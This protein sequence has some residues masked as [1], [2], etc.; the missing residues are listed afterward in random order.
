MKRAC[1]CQYFD[2]FNCKSAIQQIK[3]D[4]EWI[5]FMLTLVL[6]LIIPQYSQAINL[7][8][9]LKANN[10]KS[11]PDSLI[12]YIYSENSQID[13]LPS[14]KYIYQYNTVGELIIETISNY[15]KSNRKWIPK[16]KL[17]YENNNLIANYDWYESRMKWCAYREEFARYDSQKKAQIFETYEDIL[18][19]CSPVC[20]YRAEVSYDSIQKTRTY[21]ISYFDQK[22]QELQL[23][24]KLEYVFKDDTL[25]YRTRYEYMWNN[26]LKI[27]QKNSKNDYEY[28]TNNTSYVTYYWD[29]LMNNWIMKNKNELNFDAKKR[30]ISKQTLNMDS[31]GNWILETKQEI[32]YDRFGKDSLT[33]YSV[34]KSGKLDFIGKAL[35]INNKFGC[36]YYE[37]IYSYIS[38][39]IWQ[40]FRKVDSVF[41]EKGKNTSWIKYSWN[42]TDSSWNN[43]LKFEYKYNNQGILLLSYYSF[44]WNQIYNVWDSTEYKTYTYDKDTNKLC[45]TNYMWNYDLNKLELSDKIYYY[46]FNSTKVNNAIK[47]VDLKLYPNPSYGM[48]NIY[49]E[50][51]EEKE[52]K[53]YNSEG[54]LV[55]TLHLSRG[56]NSIDL[57]LP[58]GFYI[59]NTNSKNLTNSHKLII[60]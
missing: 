17:V 26:E 13:S 34:F 45:E 39:G 24:S 25:N 20:T 55:E 11:Q 3:N 43:D 27:W 59:I 47:N 29:T 19:T 53:V 56:T 4:V 48:I 37:N 41:N 8:I 23:N 32:I 57:K 30:L 5:F 16:K 54:S 38:T 15:N 14:S 60:Y 28:S 22:N 46:Y 52:A 51:M 44:S 33:T 50:S 9:N 35:S 2:R 31:A 10:S 42:E 6:I 40:G 58:R 12:I 1:L 18:N 7:K 36:E 21:L 49:S